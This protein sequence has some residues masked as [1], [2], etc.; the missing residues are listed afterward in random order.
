MHCWW[1]PSVYLQPW[2]LPPHSSHIINPRWIFSHVVNLCCFGL[3]NRT[4]FWY[5][6]SFSS[7]GFPW[8]YSSHEREGCIIHNHRSKYSS[9]LQSVIFQGQT[10]GPREGC[11]ELLFRSWHGGWK[12]KGPL[13]LWWWMG[14]TIRSCQQLIPLGRRRPRMRYQRKFELGSW[15]KDYLWLWLSL[16]IQPWKV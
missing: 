15:K 13:Q 5:W 3:L 10:C 4:L 11:L 8:L 12:S 6:D 2:P 1:L 9:S 16:W 14:S 7:Q